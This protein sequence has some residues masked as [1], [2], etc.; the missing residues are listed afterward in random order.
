MKN[1]NIVMPID[2]LNCKE[3]VCE[4]CEHFA[5]NKNYDPIN[6]PAHYTQG[7]IE[8]IDAIRAALGPEGFRAYCRGNVIKYVWRA[9]HKGK[10][11]EDLEKALW[12]A[13]K[14]VGEPC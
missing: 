8:C 13:R 5:K 9:E 3:G 11:Q 7:E 6:H 14:A 2:C 1:E 12:Y 10:T 4:Y